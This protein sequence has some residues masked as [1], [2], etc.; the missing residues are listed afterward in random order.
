MSGEG[1]DH[2]V[3]KVPDVGIA[4][5]QGVGLFWRRSTFQL[6]GPVPE[7]GTSEISSEVA[8]GET[9]GEGIITNV[10]YHERW[11]LGWA[12]GSDDEIFLFLFFESRTRL[13]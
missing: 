12:S 8:C 9:L 7:T 13:L 6:A 3:L 2:V 10:D 5:T 4:V 11:Q 1:F